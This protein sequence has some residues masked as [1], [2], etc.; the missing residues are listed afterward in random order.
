RDA[1][2]RKGPDA[3]LP[4]DGGAGTR[5]RAVAGGRPERR[6][7]A[8]SSGRTRASPRAAMAAGADSGDLAG[9]G[10]VAGA[11]A[12]RGAD[13]SAGTDVVSTPR[14][15]PGSRAG[16][17]GGRA[18]RGAAA[19]GTRPPAAPRAPAGPAPGEQ[20]GAVARGQ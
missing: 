14:R 10:R 2:D 13:A 11:A 15:R 17:G 19:D 4:D 1:R 6:V 7:S 8:G 9:R 18:A 12:A 20:A 3:A 16:R 5:P